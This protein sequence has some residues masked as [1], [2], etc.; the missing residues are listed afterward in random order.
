MSLH[1]RLIA[2][3]IASFATMST[4][5]A[6]STK[7]STPIVRVSIVHFSWIATPLSKSPV[8]HIV[9]DRIVFRYTID[10]HGK[11]LNEVLEALFSS[12][13]MDYD[14]HGALT[15]PVDVHVTGVG[16]DQ[17]LAAIC[18]ASDLPLKTKHVDGSPD[19]AVYRT[20][21]DVQV[22]SARSTTLDPDAVQ[23]AIAVKHMTA[24][25]MID[26]LQ[27]GV[28]GVACDEK[29]GTTPD[30]KEVLYNGDRDNY[31]VVRSMVGSLDK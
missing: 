23:Y 7:P 6:A 22:A 4:A 3:A 16:F 5:F 1:L 8:T 21:D 28:D 9:P 31:V 25:A 13:G 18:N 20:L 15:N 12:A 24:S 2:T 27:R 17:A 19:Y 10:C 30:D 14:V 29:L 26:R 11:P